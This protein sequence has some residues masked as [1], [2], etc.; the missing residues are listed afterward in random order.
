[1]SCGGFAAIGGHLTA[2]GGQVTAV[3]DCWPSVLQWAGTWALGVAA[4]E[5]KPDGSFW[6]SPG[7]RPSPSRMLLHAGPISAG[8]CRIAVME[9]RASF[10]ASCWCLPDSA[11]RM[12]LHAAF[13]PCTSTRLRVWTASHAV[14]LKTVTFGGC[15]PPQLMWEVHQCHVAYPPR[16]GLYGNPPR[17]R[18]RPRPC[19]GQT[20][21]AGQH[22]GSASK[23]RGHGGERPV[24]A[25]TYGGTGFV[26]RIRGSGERPI[27]ATSFRH[28]GV[29]ATPPPPRMLRPSRSH[30]CSP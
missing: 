17:L 6:Q 29:M 2:V 30:I 12:R 3:T 26:E 21:P 1:M 11:E 13:C 9:G 8:L 25:A 14:A 16:V 18:P 28:P 20:E 7:L 19:H 22:S 24:G 4:G 27:G 10:W 23:A 15:S 5:P